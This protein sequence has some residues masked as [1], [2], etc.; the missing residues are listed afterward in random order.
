MHA[1]HSVVLSAGA[2]GSPHLLQVSGIGLGKLLQSLDV[3]VIHE[4]AGLAE[5]FRHHYAGRT[6][7]RVNQPITLNE[8]AR[9]W[10]LG[11][12]VTKWILAH[13][14]LLAFS[15]AHVA[16]FHRSADH[17]ETPDLQF[18]FTP[19]SLQG[20]HDGIF[21]AIPGHDSGCLADAPRKP[22]L[23]PSTNAKP[24]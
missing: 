23:C 8:H 1:C 7:C 24:R 17:L 19:A 4:L 9:G 20:R 18:A 12:K 5:N 16:V 14:G 2:I 3:P 6:A 13:R 11:W 22:G 21:A 15:P 10:R